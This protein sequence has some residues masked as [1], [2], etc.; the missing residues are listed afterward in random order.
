MNAYAILNQTQRQRVSD[1]ETV[2]ILQG[3]DTASRL[4]V[5]LWSQLGDFDSCEYAEMLVKILP[6]RDSSNLCIY[7]AVLNENLVVVS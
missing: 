5:L 3:C 7:L 6:F 4:L 2:P 1:G